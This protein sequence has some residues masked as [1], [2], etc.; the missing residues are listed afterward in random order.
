MPLLLALNAG[1]STLKFAAFRRGEAESLER[2]FAGKV[3]GNGDE[4]IGEVLARVDEG[5]SGDRFEAVGHRVV[6]GG[7]SFAGPVL[8]D[9]VVLSRI[10]AL[11]PLAPL[12]QPHALAAIRAV[13]SRASDLQQVACFDTAF[14]RGHPRVAD[15]FALPRPLWEEGIRR[16]GFHGLS[17]ESIARRLPDVAPSVADGRVV[18]LHLG[19]GASLCALKERKSV[20]STMSFTALDGVP[21]GT[22]PGSV[23]PGVL[24]Y[25]LKSK[26]FD[27][28]RL[29]KLLYEESGLL[30]LSGWSSDMRELLADGRPESRLAVDFFVARVVQAAGALAATLGG[31]D[32]L[33][34]TGG[35][36]EHAA[37]VRERVVNGLS[38]L[39]A[40]L[41]T[42]ANERHEARISSRASRV[43]VLVMPAD[44][45][46]M[47]AIH[48][49]ETLDGETRR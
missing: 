14:H 12:H 8:V 18:A 27:A 31:L 23:D 47:I 48:V 42:G 15:H 4:A 22:R 38:F 30:G 10:E 19:N 46:R 16:Y 21:M 41:D 28:G 45:E 49:R 33:V 44:E 9:D 26:G 13:T 39:G 29:E 17:Y 40:E 43:D 34:F 5:L 37:V 11:V 36:G 32:V 35:I 1:S 20:D 3:E 24:L 7:P 6:H 25:L 2:V